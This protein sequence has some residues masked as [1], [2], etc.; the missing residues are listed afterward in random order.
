MT[1]SVVAESYGGPEVLALQDIDVPEPGPGEILVAVRAAGANPIDYKLYSGE[2]GSDPDNLP[3]PVG[4]EVAGV[5][6]AHGPDAEG[7]T[8][9]LTIGDEVIVTNVQGGYSERLIAPAA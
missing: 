8:G 3:L 6:L 4:L 1:K 5:V 2:M 9:P 7:Y